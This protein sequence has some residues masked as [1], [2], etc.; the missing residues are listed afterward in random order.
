MEKMPCP[1]CGRENV[2]DAS[3]SS[4]C[5]CGAHLRVLV[6]LYAETAQPFGWRWAA[7]C[8]VCGEKCSDVEVAHSI[9]MLHA[10]TCGACAGEER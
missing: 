4:L 1:S 7:L 3:G 2:K 5:P 8:T 9:G 10:I 6:P